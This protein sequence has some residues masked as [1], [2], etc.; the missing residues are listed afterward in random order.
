VERE[1]PPH[2]T[3]VASKPIAVARCAIRP[4][5]FSLRYLVLAISYAASGK[6]A[7]LLAVPPGYASPVFPPAGIAVG[8][9]LIGGSA[10]LPWTFLGSLAL[11]V[12]TGYSAGRGITVATLAAAV[13]IAAAS[14]LQAAVGGTA[15][16]RAVGYPAPLDNGRDLT[17]F[18][19]LSPAFC[20]TSATVSLAGLLAFGVVELPDLTT[21]WVSW[22]IGD[23]L[24]VLV[25]LPLIL[26]V[27]GEPRS[28]WRSRALSV[29]LPMVLFFVLFVTIF[30]R[31]S[32]WEHEASL[33]EFRLLSHQIVDKIRAGLEEQEVFLEQLER[34]FD[35][36]VT[37]SAADFHHLV[38]KLLKRFPRIQAVE[39]APRI[40]STQRAAFEAA[41]QP[42]MPGFEVRE[43]A[44]AGYSRRAGERAQYYPVTYIEPL[45][46]NEKA[47]GFD[48]ASDPERKA[49]IETAMR[50]G[51]LAASAPVR[52]VQETA[53]QLG[54]LLIYP[55]D[56]SAD[57]GVLL[58]AH[59]MGTFLEGVLA[60][61]ES[62]VGMRLV[63]L[64]TDEVL[65]DALSPGRSDASY[66]DVFTFGGRS[67]RIKTAP[68]S[69]YTDQH[70]SLQSWAVLMRGIVG[71]SLLGA[72]LLLGTGYARRIETVVKER[73]RDLE[74]INRRL[75]LE[76]Q[77]RQQAEAALRQAQRMEAIG[78]LTGGVAH[79]FNNLLMVVGG[80]AA[81]LGES[82][83]DDAVRRRTSTIMR[84]VER[85]ERLTRQ[86]LAFSRRQMLRPEPVDLQHRMPEIVELLSRSL[87]DDIELS[88]Q[89][90]PDLWPVRV[91]P[92]ELELALLNI[93]VN[94]RD[95]MPNGGRLQIRACNIS[96]APD[97]G[98]SE[99][100]VGDFIELELSDNG[101]GMPAEVRTRAFEP[102]F[103]TKEI[104]QGSGLGLSQVYGFVKQ[105]GGAV[106]IHSDTGKGTSITLY[107]PRANA[108]SVEC[109]AAPAEDVPVVAPTRILVVEDDHEVAELATQLLQDIGCCA[110][111]AH[112]GKSALALLDRDPTIGLMLS[113]VVMPGGMNGIELA[114]IVRERRPT[115]PILLATGYSQH[116]LQPMSEGFTLIEKPYDRNTLAAA[117]RLAIGSGYRSR[118]PIAKCGAG[119]PRS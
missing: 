99:K 52:L 76:I 8:A 24:G 117:I 39:W 19:L 68:T 34:S 114:Q 72:L 25:G 40:A 3:Q 65:F 46:G 10:T 58:V 110:V 90:P 13:V 38:E 26:V 89:L 35:G 1:T 9:M 6:V 22:W 112:D 55:V 62:S 43:A 95:A 87:R 53:E 92:A 2:K 109:H 78:Q 116:A 70:R 106:L 105:S 29:A 75:Q 100:L 85:G 93:G 54:I 104:G 48:L 32:K 51:G 42:D 102:F 101:S 47:V 86:L 113:D 4:M 28:L 27:A 44:A 45:R 11:N 50:T 5:W 12:W 23:T 57:T 97:S 108:S 77:E 67:Y 107:L 20:I 15:L 115:L 63:D 111:Q 56:G 71:T 36:S 14:M 79:D 66:E 59:R 98:G 7:L 41:R 118:P 91:D 60:P 61:F 83:R 88:F 49:T 31:V 82:A 30:V 81:L 84:A 74:A 96:F 64:Q 37:P 103:T 80:N 17:R 69:L 94:A 18:L 16:R 73:T 33:L 119:P 21:N